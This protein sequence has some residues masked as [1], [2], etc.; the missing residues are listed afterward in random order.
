MN[1]KKLINIFVHLFLALLVIVWVL[2]I[3]W[4]IL[5]SFRGEQ[6]A[7]TS[8]V[9]LKHIQLIITFVYL[10]KL[11]CLIFHYGLGIHLS[12]LVLVV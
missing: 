3:I 7:Y 11:I 8:T 1:K 10:Q 4:I 12:L 2:P 9:Y 5:I 6:G